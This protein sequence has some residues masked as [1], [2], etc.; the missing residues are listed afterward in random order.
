MMESNGV[1]HNETLKEEKIDWQW[2]S[3][4]MEARELGLSPNDVRAFLQTAA[5]RIP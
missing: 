4:L 1:N 2:V 5:K 3:L